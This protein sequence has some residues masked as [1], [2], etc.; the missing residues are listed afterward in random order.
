L[1]KIDSKEKLVPLAREKWDLGDRWITSRLQKVAGEINAAIAEYR[2]D[3]AANAAYQFLWHEFCDWYIEW[4]KPQLNPEE[5]DASA[6]K[7]LLLKRISEVLRLLHPFVPFI[8]EYLWQQIPPSIRKGDAVIAA[9]YPILNQSEVDEN[10]ERDFAYLSELIGKIRQVR[11]EMNIEP[12]KKVHVLIKGNTNRTL[13]GMQER[14]ILLLTRAERLEFVE[15]F[16]ADLH[17]ARGVLKD[18]E[19]G[20]DLTGVLDVQAEI[21]RLTRDLKKIEIELGQVNKK[22][23]NENF[24][25]NAPPEIVIEQ[26]AKYEDLSARKQKTEENLS[27]LK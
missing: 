14:E 11:S 18:C 3:L 6:K 22:L 9:P 7:G 1:L 5:P 8:T 4:I 2:F 12:A 13:I 16:P 27:S 10:A 26:K 23:S 19:I 17:I 24:M 25:K 15:E 20:I 21:E